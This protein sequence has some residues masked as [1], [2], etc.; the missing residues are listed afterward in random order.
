MCFPTIFVGFMSF[1]PNNLV[2]SILSLCLTCV[3]FISV[4]QR[5]SEGV[6]MGL[7]T[8]GRARLSTW[9]HPV[10]GD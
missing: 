5:E 2:F 6:N 3:S 9:L 10:P 8:P 7:K 4:K 1:T